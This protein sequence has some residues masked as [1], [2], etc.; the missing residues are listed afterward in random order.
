M[1][2]PLFAMER[3]QSTWENL[4]DYNLSESGVHPMRLQELVEDPAERAGLLGQELVYPQSNG[5]VELRERVAAMYPG[6]TADHVEV[7]NGGSEA[8]FV[9]MWHLV[10]PGDEVVSMVPNYGQTLGLAEAFGGTLRPWRLRPS[11]DGARWH[12]DLDDLRRLVTGRTRLVILC[13]PNNPTGARIPASDLDA[14][15]EIAG[16]VGAWVLSDEIYRGAE[17]DGVETPSVWGRYERVIITSGLSKAYGLPGLRIGWVVSAPK[18]VATTWGYHDYTTIGPGTLSDRL[19]RIALQPAMRAR[20]L[21]RTRRILQTNLPVIAGWL[22][23]HPDRFSYAAPEA[24]AIVYVRYHDAINSTELVDRL[25]AEK[26]VLIVPGDHFGMDGYLRI[27]FGSET[28]YL[29]DG[30]DR[31]DHLLRSLPAV[32]AVK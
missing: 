20:I 26:S 17:L 1:R 30:L 8:N 3:M 18:V 2:I 16:K 19:A 15:C 31:L 21:A 29:R 11:A 13:N 32:G 22:D 25:R 28:R 9:T 6:A 5:T 24:G 10:E 4:V 7:T 23:A 12:V 27:G 14:V